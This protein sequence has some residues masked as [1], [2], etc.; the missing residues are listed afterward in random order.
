MFYI[1]LQFS[2]IESEKSKE[3]TDRLIKNMVPDLKTNESRQSE[4]IR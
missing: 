4:N 2:F 3:K 1:F